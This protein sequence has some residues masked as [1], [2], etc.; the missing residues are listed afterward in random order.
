MNIF[1]KYS[2]ILT[3][4]SMRGKGGRFAQVA[5][6]EVRVAD[7]GIVVKLWCKRLIG[8]AQCFF[9]NNENARSSSRRHALPAL[10]ARQ[11]L[12]FHFVCYTMPNSHVSLCL[13]TPKE[14]NRY[15]SPIPIPFMIRECDNFILPGPK[16]Y[17]IK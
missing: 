7:C 4:S 11:L 16:L 9:E 3:G 13:S 15:P 10:N 5:G 14:H 17:T 2:H 1:G 6:Y 8:V 12:S